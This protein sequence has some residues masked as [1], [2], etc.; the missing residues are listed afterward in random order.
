MATSNARQLSNFTSGDIITVDSVNNR[1]GI[2]STL[3]TS[4][5]EVSGDIISSG[6]ITATSFVGDGSGLTGVGAALTVKQTQGNGGTVD[7]TVSSVSSLIFDAN[8]GFNVTNN[9]GGEVFVDLGSSFAPWYITDDNFG[10]TNQNDLHPDGEEAIEIISGPGIAITTKSTSSG[11]GTGLSKSLTISNGYQTLYS[12]TTGIDNTA[13]GY[14]TLWSNTTGSNNTASGYQALVQNTTA[15]F[16][17]AFGYKSLY[18]N[19]TGGL[20]SA[21]GPFCLYS[22]TTGNYNSGYGVEC[23]YSNS[24]ASNNTAN[25]WKSLYTSTTASNNTASGYKAMYG[26]TTGSYCT[27]FGVESLFTNTTGWYNTASGYK[28]LY[29]NTTGSRNTAFGSNA[30]QNNTTASYGGAFGYAALQNNTTGLYNYSFG[31]FSQYGGTTGS[32]NHSM[33]MYSLYSNSSGNYNAAIGY[34]ACYIGSSMYYCVGIGYRALYRNTG[35]SNI[36]IGYETFFDNTYGGYNVGIGYRALY[37]NTTAGQ[38]SLVGSYS[39]YNNTTG[40]YN[41]S[42]GYQ[43]LYNNSTGNYNT[44][45]GYQSLYNNTS[46]SSNIGL[47]FVNSSGTRAPVFDP[48]TESNRLVMGHTSITNAYVQVAWTVTSDARDKMNF[49]PVPYGL[50]FVN[51]LKPTSYQFKVDRGTEKPNGDVRYGF[52]AQDILALEGDNPV[53]IDTEDPDNL[54]YKGEHLVPVLVNAVQ[55]LTTMVN[56]LKS[57]IATLKNS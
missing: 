11:I 48:T 31:A 23:L 26:T 30:F 3:P 12:N 47:G 35:T 10:N 37:N 38:N 7:V 1:V 46:G 14:Q 8:T 57:E 16:N 43:S 40:A 6:I 53:I 56:D 33:G 50:D 17:S 5:F 54:K 39:G 29:A 9:G 20:N 28:S 49:A 36:G 34:Q 2:A 51:Q 45:L 44:A 22:N 19:T 42:L 52:K 18:S 27:S 55:E 21:F 25:G 32:Y 15:S 4:T 24:T 13:S 41:S